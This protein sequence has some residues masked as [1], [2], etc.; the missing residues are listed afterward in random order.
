MKCHL[1][2]DK[3]VSSE[4]YNDIN[5]HVLLKVRG[6]GWELENNYIRHAFHNFFS[7]FFFLSLFFIVAFHHNEPAN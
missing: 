7:L 3:G 2:I 6:L 4:I 1:M 5:K